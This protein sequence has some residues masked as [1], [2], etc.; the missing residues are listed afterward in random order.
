MDAEACHPDPPS[1]LRASF[2]QLVGVQ[3]EVVACSCQLTCSKN[4]PRIGES[5]L[6]PSHILDRKE[7]K[8]GPFHSN[9]LSPRA[10]PNELLIGAFSVCSLAILIQDRYVGQA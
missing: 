9:G 3:V 7:P 1:G 10:L 4:W 8:I 6:A 5:C 2:L